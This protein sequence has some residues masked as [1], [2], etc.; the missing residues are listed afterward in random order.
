MTNE[1]Q[2]KQMTTKQLAK[3]LIERSCFHCVH[4]PAHKCNLFNPT[5]SD[6]IDGTTKWLAAVSDVTT[7][8][9]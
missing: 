9:P 5:I 7:V 6:C 2:L 4:Q 3:F 1:E 8:N